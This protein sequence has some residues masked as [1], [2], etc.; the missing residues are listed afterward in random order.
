MSPGAPEAPAIHLA[1]PVSIAQLHGAP[2][3]SLS[4]VPQRPA[5]PSHSDYMSR[6]C[7]H[8]APARQRIDHT[9]GTSRKDSAYNLGQLGRQNGNRLPEDRTGDTSAATACLARVP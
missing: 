7:G 1:L 9:T 3:V 8:S 4:D 5:V 2:V 6:A